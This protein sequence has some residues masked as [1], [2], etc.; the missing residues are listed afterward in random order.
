MAGLAQGRAAADDRLGLR[1]PAETLL[2]GAVRTEEGRA[3]WVRP[4]RLFE[5]QL[6]VLGSTA[7]WHPGLYRQMAR[8]SAGVRLELETD[9]RTLALELRVDETPAGSAAVLD[10]VRRARPDAPALLDGVSL[11]MD[12]HHQG[13]L[14]P[15]AGAETLWLPLGEPPSGGHRVCLWLPCLAGCELRELSCDG[16]YLRPVPACPRLLVVGDSIAQGFVAGDPAL[17]WPSVL[18]GRLGLDLL[19]WSIGG[20]VFQ[21]GLVRV[22]ADALDGDPALVIVALGNNYRFEP[23]HESRMRADARAVLAE[24]AQAWPGAPLVALT[25][26][27]FSESL[28]QSDPHGCLGAVPGAVRDAAALVGA[29]V[30]EGPLLLDDDATLLADGSDHPDAHGMA[31]MARRLSYLVGAGHLVR[32]DLRE[33]ALGLLPEGTATFPLREMLRRDI[34]EVLFADTGCVL[35]R[36]ADGLQAVWGEDAALARR[37]LGTLGA[38][39]KL[40]VVSPGLVDVAC[41]ALGFAEGRPCHLCL[42][43]GGRLGLGAGRDIRPLGPDDLD[44]VRARYSH[45]E[46]LRPG[47]LEGLVS[48]GDLLGGFESGGLVGFVGRHAEGSVGMLEVFPGHRRQGWGAALEAAA[49]NL[50]LSRGEVPWLE[51]WPGN[52]ASLALQRR[53]GLEVRPAGEMRFMF[54]PGEP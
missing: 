48:T 44:A 30:V 2:H 32:A 47:E 41:D 17:A 24:A 7:A 13:P 18:A 33:E 12:G 26:T 23:C 22:G 38:P 34:A 20:S 15:A 43:R 27:P 53:L 3:G 29:Q 36:A 5:G 52:V 8:S 4:W 54:L 16:S 9:A 40:M 14:V 51:V 31:Q 46:W 21:P 19:N 25:P 1:V 45:A 42:W 11:D 50:Q 6:R 35:L 39:T 28:Y 37:V 10:D 49:I